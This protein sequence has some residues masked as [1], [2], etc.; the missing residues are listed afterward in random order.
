[1]INR[2]SI[3]IEMARIGNAYEVRAVDADDGLEIAF[4]APLNTPEAE[5]HLLAQRKLDYVRRKRANENAPL[6]SEQKS[7][8]RGIIV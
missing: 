1:M 5:I 4:I 2:S 7:S 6:Q 8:R 3:L